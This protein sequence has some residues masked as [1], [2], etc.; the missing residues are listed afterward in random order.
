[1]VLATNEAMAPTLGKELPKRTVKAKPKLQEEISL[2]TKKIKEEEMWKKRDTAKPMSADSSQQAAQSPSQPEQ[3]R[4]RALKLK[5]S[6]QCDSEA[7]STKRPQ[8]RD[9]NPIR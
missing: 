7:K 9:N 2:E 6:Q 3:A 4:G 8:S 1:M 5:S